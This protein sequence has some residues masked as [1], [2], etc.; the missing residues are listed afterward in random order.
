MEVVVA[1]DAVVDPDAVVVGLLDAG[2]ADAA[3]F[4]A[5]GFG[6]VA[7]SAGLGVPGLG[8]VEDGVVWRVGEHGGGVV[9]GAYGGRG[10]L[11]Q[12]EE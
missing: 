4:A 3:V 8:R 1:A 10:R 9:F 12:V 2:A 5:C 11:G 6:A 7:A